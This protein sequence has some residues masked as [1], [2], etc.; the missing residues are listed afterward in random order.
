MM[1]K[2]K[3]GFTLVELSAVLVII[4]VLA[5]IVTPLV[6]SLVNGAKLLANMRSVEAYGKAIETALSAYQLDNGEYPE[7][8]SLLKTEYTGKEVKCDFMHTNSNG[9]IYLSECSVGGVEVKDDTTKDGWYHYGGYTKYKVGDVISFSGSKWYVLKDSDQEQSYVTL[10]KDKILSY[11]ELGDYGYEYHGVCS[12]W[13]VQDGDY[14]CTEVGQK[15]IRKENAMPYY[16]SDTCHEEGDYGYT[17]WDNSECRGHNDYE[18]SK[19]RE[20]LE[21]HYLPKL[22]EKELVE[23]DGYKIRLL[24]EKELTEDFGYY[25]SEKEYTDDTRWGIKSIENVPEWLY[26]NFGENEYKVSSYWTSY[27]YGSSKLNTMGGYDDNFGESRYYYF[28]TSGV[29]PVIN[30]KK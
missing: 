2:T 20:M 13:Q 9:S 8:I 15:Y 1:L 4:S 18:G 14:G 21:N 10:L 23:V 27:I 24:T 3:K 19:V 29:R 30:L 6:I 16:W 7:G 17:E 12:D 26:K 11:E 5:L 25:K 22:D 28:Q